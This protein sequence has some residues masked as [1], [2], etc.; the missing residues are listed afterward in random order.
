MTQN[1]VFFHSTLFTQIYASLYPL[2][3]NAPFNFVVSPVPVMDCPY[4]SSPLS[5]TFVGK[6]ESFE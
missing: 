5:W 1:Y 3:K 2:A 4:L 6:L